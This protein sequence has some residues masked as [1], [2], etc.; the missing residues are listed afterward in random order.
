MTRRRLIG[1]ALAGVLPGLNAAPALDEEILDFFRVVEDPDGF[2][3]V[4]SGPSTSAKVVGRV[5]SGCAVAVGASESGWRRIEDETGGG[6]T[7]FV[8][9]SRLKPIGGWKQTRCRP[10]PGGK[11]ARVESGGLKAVVR[12]VRFDAKAHRIVRP[13]PGE[14]GALTIDGHRVVGTDGEIPDASLELEMTIGGK[15]VRVP[16]EAT[17]DLYQPNL[18][19][20]EDLVLVTPGRAADHALVF[21]WGSDGAGGYMVGWSFVK[22]AYAGRAVF[23]GF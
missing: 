17:R 2:V 16:A 18:G 9:G 12:E 6:R 15:P 13:N 11:Q 8:H 19:R 20:E 10:E 1:S 14:E 23:T 7:L 3:N 21:L 22:G 5:L 4:R